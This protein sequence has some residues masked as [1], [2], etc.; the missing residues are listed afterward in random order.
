MSSGPER[1]T[2]PADQTGH[3][4]QHAD[5]SGQAQIYQAGRDQHLHL[6]EGIFETRRTR[7]DGSV[8][9]YPGL[10]AF[11]D[12]QAEWFFG[13]DRLT[14]ELTSRAAMLVTQG[15]LL[16][17]VAGSGTGKSS[18]LRAGL[19]PALSQGRLP[20]AG[21]Q[22]WPQLVLT[23]GANPTQV[24]AG[25][26]A[27]LVGEEPAAV[28]QGMI[29]DP[30]AYLE[31]LRTIVAR[32]LA[33]PAHQ[34]VRVVIVAD[35]MEELFTLCTDLRQRQMFVDWLALLAAPTSAG[36][37]P[38]LVVCGLRSDFYARCADYPALCEAL[39]HD[40]V[41]VRPMSEGELRQAI[42]HPA[43]SV[44][45]QLEAGLAELLLRDMGGPGHRSDSEAGSYEPGRLPF[46]AHAL[47][48]TWQQRHGATL[49]VAGYQST[50]GIAHAIA[51]TADRVYASLTRAD[52]VLA[53]RLLLRLVKVGDG[54][55]DSRRRAAPDD[56]MADL[57]NREP[58]RIAAVL[59]AF[60][61]ARLLT[62]DQGLVEISHEALIKGWPQLRQWITADRVG[63]LVWQNLEEVAVVWDR[64][65]RRDG[66]LLYQGARLRAA[67]DWATDRPAEEL[68]PRAVAFLTASHRH[69]RRARLLRGGAVIAL[70]VLSVVSSTAAV[71][72]ISSSRKS[73]SSSREARHQ[74]DQAILTQVIAEADNLSPTDKTLAAQLDLIAYR[75]A[76]NRPQLSPRPEQLST[77]LLDTQSSPLS[78]PLP[79]NT[80]TVLSVAFAPDGR[81]LATGSADHSVRLWNIT[82]PAH[83][84]MLVAPRIAPKAVNSVAFAPDG[85]TLATGGD[86]DSVRLWNITDPIHPMLD[87]SV[88]LD[89]YNHEYYDHVYSVAFAPDGHTLATGSA[90]QKVR[91]WNITDPTHPVALG[92]PLT[93]HTQSVLSVTFAPDGRTLATG[94]FDHTVR[95]WNTTDP[96]HP[97]ALGAP[98]TDH[99]GAVRSVAFAPDGRT[100]ATASSDHTVR[101]W[102]TTDR[103]H[104]TALGPPLTDHTDG[105]RSVAFAPDGRTLATASSDHTVRL[106]N[107]TDR[108]HPTALG[109]PLTDHTSAVLSVAFA[110]DGRMLASAS[111]DHTARIWKLPFGLLTGHTDGVSSLAFSRDGHTLATGSFDHTVRLWNTTDP[112]H[113]TAL[114]PPLTGHTGAVLSVAFT[115]DGHTL[116]TASSDH[117][118]RLWNTTDPAHPTAHGPPLTAHAGAGFS[119]VFAPD[120][121][122][123]ATPDADDYVQLWDVTDPAHPT[124]VGP[125]LTAEIGEVSAVAFAPV[126]R[127]IAIGDIVGRVRLWN[128]S[129]PARS[130]GFEPITAHTNAVSAMTFAPDGRTLATGGNDHSVR[131][132]NMANSRYVTPPVALGPS[133][134]GHTGA[135]SAV[136]FS[137]DGRTLA[138]ASL[139]HT[140]RLWN[141]T[142]RAHPSILGP[143]LTGH[144]GAVS[145]VAFTPDG[146]ILANASVDG[147]VGLLSLRVPDATSWICAATGNSFTASQWITYISRDL[148]YTPPCP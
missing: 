73:I 23:P 19:L 43:G 53:R 41:L 87:A 46:L 38:A 29:R 136:A 145:A 8:C 67:D 62:Q 58:D 35:Q 27:H 15:G 111:Q 63:H 86:D 120:G 128:V 139:D 122:T 135:V 37:P 36:P 142:D 26:L 16:M 123:L 121:R 1:S 82:D 97:T 45:L 51:T 133:L 13:R 28:L 102:N 115:S 92:S 42:V 101:L 147:T 40:Q 60:T 65:G 74:R 88:D 7:P 75:M 69:Q 17:V 99:T 116:A 6:H 141:A 137:P 49:T 138:S 131:L 2:S 33:A 85:R 93:G 24:L 130:T 96:A 9:P 54:V 47:Q 18:L 76:Q 81:T 56:L 10:A 108:A 118:V 105:V 64:T 4:V 146:H 78:Q 84:V 52:Q 55:D 66:S 107:T 119:V 100:L 3:V 127:T 129:N 39:Q 90:D 44:G 70:A 143:P 72:A 106:W 144:T 125:P 14:A 94:S 140:M 31:H 95:L 79:G 77:R 91:L 68:S 59:N 134:T 48:A 124:A 103:A 61:Q 21:S 50:G 12:A 11:T 71:V 34:S 112:A 22:R 114:G 20:V 83:P 110:P 148:P 32:Q 117:T 80:D 104:P 98:L 109:P 30:R 126:G 113:P 25:H 57:G 132:W 5:A 89:Y